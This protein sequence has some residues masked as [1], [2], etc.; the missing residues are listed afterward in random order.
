M[1][2]L[3]GRDSKH[4]EDKSFDVFLHDNIGQLEHG[5]EKE[6]DVHVNPQDGRDPL[7]W[8]LWLKT[9]CLVQVGLLGALG[10]LNTAIINPA[11]TPMAKEL[12]IT[13]HRASYQT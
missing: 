11:Y 4:G 9:S 5:D 10:N 6:H 1:D 7:N 12:G 13:V 2:E 3:P 8:P